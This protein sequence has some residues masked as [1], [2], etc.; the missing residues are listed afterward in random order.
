[1][2]YGKTGMKDISISYFFQGGRNKR[3]ESN[4]NYAKEMFYGFH[5]FKNNYKNVILREFEPHKTIFGKLFFKIIEKRLRN[6]LK[7]PLYWSFMT[8]KTNYK[9]IKNSDFSVFSSN[10]IGCSALPMVIV[11]KIFR[12]KNTTLSFILGLFSRKPRFFILEIFQKIYI[13][14]FLRFIDKFIFLSEGEYDYAVEN[15]SK[16]KNKFSLLPFAVDLN[17]W[18]F[19]K[20]Q[21]EKKNI[22]FVGNDGFRDFELAEKLSHEILNNNFVYISE[23][24]NSENVNMNNSIIKKGSWGSPIISDSELKNEYY[25]AK[26]TIIPLKDSL[27]PSGQSVALQSLACGTPVLITNTKGFWDKKNFL[28]NKN[29]FFCEDNKLLTWVKKINSILEKNENELNELILDSQ[30]LVQ[31]RYSLD[32]FSKEIEKIL[33]K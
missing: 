10:R 33:M 1:M 4:E 32:K 15:Y 12:T 7:L 25:K 14:L 18:K 9:I 16:W 17:M 22:L 23:F 5:Y 29:I 20:S 30:K 6:Y 28:D 19:E 26:L 13:N 31:N 11:S 8:N 3:I 21:K 27:Q 2:F 24:I